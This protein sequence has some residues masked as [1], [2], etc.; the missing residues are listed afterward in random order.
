MLPSPSTPG[1]VFV[2][3]QINIFPRKR[4]TLTDVSA[5]LLHACRVF[6]LICVQSKWLFEGW[7]C[8]IYPAVLIF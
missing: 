1:A 4:W 7:M 2:H 8:T 6:C 5:T 3:R